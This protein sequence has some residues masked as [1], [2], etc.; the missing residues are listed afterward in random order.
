MDYENRKILLE[1]EIRSVL[2]KFHKGGSLGEATTSIVDLVT[3]TN[4]LM[5]RKILYVLGGLKMPKLEGKSKLKED[6]QF[7]KGFNDAASQN[8]FAVQL[9]IDTFKKINDEEKI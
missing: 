6:R 8:N 5:E 7:V 9:T 3:D 1:K 2:I 4:S